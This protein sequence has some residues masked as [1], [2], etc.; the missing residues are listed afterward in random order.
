MR[1]MPYADTSFDLVL[2]V[3]TLEHVGMDNSMYGAPVSDAGGDL[4]A[5]REVNPILRPGGRLPVTIPFGLKQ[6]LDWFHQYDNVEWTAL[7]AASGL[8]ESERQTYEYE[9]GWQLGVP[10][11]AYSANQAPGV[12]GV[13]WAELTRPRNVHPRS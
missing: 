7:V 4:A 11:V 1:S 10:A 2:C 3:S 13:L 8:V 5:L 12:A 6:N 9:Q